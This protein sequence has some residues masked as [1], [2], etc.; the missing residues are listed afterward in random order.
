MSSPIAVLLSVAALAPKLA[1][2]PGARA[3]RVVDA[4]RLDCRA[5]GPSGETQPLEVVE[6][7]SPARP[8]PIPSAR[9]FDNAP[10]SRQ[11][12]SLV[13]LR[14]ILVTALAV[15]A[16]PVAASFGSSPKPEAM[17]VQLMRYYS[18]EQ[19]GRAYDLLHPGQKKFVSRD[20][21]ATCMQRDFPRF[22]LVSIKKIDQYRDPIDIVGVPQR[23]SVA[24]TFRMTLGSPNGSKESANLTRH[25]VWIGTR[26]AWFFTNDA[27]A[28][29]RK[30]QCPA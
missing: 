17:M 11:T 28:S 9:R 23:T 3:F 16:M 19:F 26:W 27:V 5:S 1:G 10:E 4:V 12:R 20:K 30:S 29:Y 15:L 24:V 14:A 13:K 7:V 22:D 18:L 21:F 2:E 25:A 8:V 6:E